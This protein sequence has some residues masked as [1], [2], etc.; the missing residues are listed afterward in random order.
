MSINLP[1]SRLINI[2][3][4]ITPQLVQGQSLSTGLVLGTSTVIDTVSRMRTYNTLAAVGVDFGT[5]A[6][7]YLAA[8]V[9]FGQSPQ[10]QSLNIGRWC[11]AAAAGRL[12]CAGLTA[13]NSLISAWTSINAGSF[14]LGV[15]GGATTNVPAMNFTGATTLN[16]VAAIMQT[17]IQGLGGSYAA[18]TCIYNSV[19]NRFEI[20]SGTTGS[21]S[22]VSFATAGTTGTD[23]S[24]QMGGLVTSGGYVANGV[25]AESALAAVLLFDNQFGGQ[26]YNLFIP[27]AVDSDHTAIAPYIDADVIAHFYW[28]NTQEQQVLTT[29]DTTH[30]GYLLQQLQSQHTAWQYSSTSL[31]A[32]WSMAARIST[33]NYAGS[34]TCISLMYK[35][36]PGIA[37]ETLTTSQIN[38]LESY[39]GNVFVNYQGNTLINGQAVQT[40]VPILEPGVCP[41]GQFIDTIQ[42]VDAFRIQAQ[43]N[44]FNILFGTPT[45]IPQTDPG[46]NTLENGVE[47]ACSQFIINGLGAPGTWNSNGFGQLTPGQF[48]DKG[49][50]IY[51]QPIALQAPSQRAARIAPPIQVAFKLAGAVDTV[52][53]TFF[54]NS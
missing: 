13:A 17:A 10:P 54:V 14:K 28:V 18:V 2:G 15:D 12:L 42:G 53:G 5:V 8:Q 36:E 11:Q 25:A 33:T 26:W 23:I 49:Y 24:G 30:I 47:S 22:A 40:P 52:S 4:V 45:K 46:I 21:A 37:A 38:A 32:V 7:E 39:N 44:L 16:G 34:N 41:S 1:I 31:Y 43:T 9:W 48:L 19:Y 50:Y 20:T 51:A 6:Q 35:T 27:S 3:V 29:G